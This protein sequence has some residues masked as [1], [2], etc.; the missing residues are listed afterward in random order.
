MYQS[1]L[2]HW[3]TF[4]TGT[5]WE[6]YSAYCQPSLGRLKKT[7]EEMINERQK[8][9]IHGCNKPPMLHGVMWWVL[10]NR[11]GKT[12]WPRVCSSSTLEQS[13][14]SWCIHSPY[15]MQSNPCTPLQRIWA[16]VFVQRGVRSILRWICEPKKGNWFIVE[17][18]CTFSTWY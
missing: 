15:W 13:Q 12:L 4:L 11:W 10:F 14:V 18:G 2:V 1:F 8:P 3:G 17:A 16:C 6:S 5:S 9:W 7:T